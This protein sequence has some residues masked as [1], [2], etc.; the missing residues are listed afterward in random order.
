MSGG[1]ACSCKESK[2]PVTNRRWY[3]WKRH[4]NNSRFHGGYQASDYSAVACQACGASWRTKAAYVDDLPDGD[5]DTNTIKRPP[6]K[7]NGRETF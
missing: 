7:D 3:V 2:K 4:F 5:Y 6:K 1:I